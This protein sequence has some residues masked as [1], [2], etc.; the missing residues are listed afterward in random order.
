MD[1]Q[2]GTFEEGGTV[3][4]QVCEL[5]YWETESTFLTQNYK[6]V[7]KNEYFF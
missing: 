6:T 2:L 4:Y 5:F 7:F 1:S 3:I